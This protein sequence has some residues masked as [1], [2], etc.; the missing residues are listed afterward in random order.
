M[1]DPNRTY[2][3][4]DWAGE[5]SHR[6]VAAADQLEAQLAPVSDVLFAAAGLQ[7]GERVLD[8]G[9]GRATTSRRAA[10]DIGTTGRVTAV[11]V[12]AELLDAARALASDGAPIEYIEGDGQRLELPVGAFDVLLSR[13]GVMFFDDASIAMANLGSA[14]RPGG[15]LCVAVWLP[16]WEN[17][18]MQWPIDVAAEVARSHGFELVSPDPNLGPFAWGDETWVT[19]M[20]EGAGWTDVHYAPTPMTLYLGGPSSP[21]DALVTSMAVG[22]LRAALSEEGVTEDFVAEVRAA[23]LD[24]F[25]ERHDGIGVPV[26]AMPAIVTATRI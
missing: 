12:S 6:W 23:L 17:E 1:S 13:F 21:E 9:C 4:D 8:V 16:R 2:S 26:S 25:T 22:P 24:A 19:S 15:R 20:L 5:T 11:D 18:M 10:A 14:I 3:T 7:K